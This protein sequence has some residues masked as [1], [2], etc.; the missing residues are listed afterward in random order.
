MKEGKESKRS[1]M[2]DTGRTVGDVERETLAEGL[3]A[4]KDK[5][6]GAEEKKE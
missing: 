3:T 5:H 6:T 4:T 1:R 2:V